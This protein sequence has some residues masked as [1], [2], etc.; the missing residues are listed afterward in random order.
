[1][2]KKVELEVV[3]VQDNNYHMSIYYDLFDYNMHQFHMKNEENNHWYHTNY[4][5]HYNYDYYEINLD[6]D[7]NVVHIEKKDYYIHDYYYND[8]PMSYC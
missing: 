1:M 8:N 3:W 2:H 7:L 6:H 5:V 4:Y